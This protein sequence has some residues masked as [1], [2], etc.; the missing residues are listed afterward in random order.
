MEFLYKVTK[1]TE[2]ERGVAEGREKRTKERAKSKRSKCVH[3]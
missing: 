3:Q 1:S 2:I